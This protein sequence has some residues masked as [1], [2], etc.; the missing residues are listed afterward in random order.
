MK[1][2]RILGLCLAVL[3]LFSCAG[4]S[5]GSLSADGSAALSV[6]VSLEPQTAALVRRMFAAGGVTTGTVL[7]GPAIAKSMSNTPGIV[8]VILR[9]IT[10]SAVEGNIQISQIGEFLAGSRQNISGRFIVFEQGTSGRCEINVNRD[11]GPVILELL[12]SQIAGYLNALMAPVATG[13]EMSKSEYLELV[14]SFYNK[15]I[16]DE[17]AAS[18]IRA[19]IE[20]PGPVS[21]VRGG[22]FSGRR[23]EFD[24]PLVDLLVLETPLSY[25]VRWGQANTPR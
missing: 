8:S 3:L 5:S 20:F 10:P 18:R 12:S 2:Y 16:S 17:I 11:N 24:I 19:S 25:E 9:N 4:Q 14:A 7:D 6:S 1:L 23:V 21:S 15:P 22:T 13:E